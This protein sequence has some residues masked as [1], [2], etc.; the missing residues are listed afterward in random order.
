M[1]LLLGVGALVPAIQAIIHFLTQ[2][3]SGPSAF[4]NSLSFFVQ[5]IIE[6]TLE[7]NFTI[8][9]WAVT[10]MSFFLVGAGIFLKVREQDAT[11]AAPT[12]VTFG[13]NSPG[14][15]QGDFKI[16]QTI[17]QEYRVSQT[18]TW[19]ELSTFADIRHRS[20][21]THEAGWTRNLCE[22][23]IETSDRYEK[24]VFLV[25]KEFDQLRGQSVVIYHV[26][27]HK[28]QF[29]HALGKKRTATLNMLIKVATAR[30]SK[31]LRK[32]IERE[33]EKA[34]DPLSSWEIE[35]D[36][37]S[38]Y[39]NN[40]T[41]IEVEIDPTTRKLQLNM[42]KQK[43]LKP[44]DYENHLQSTSEFLKF[45]AAIDSSAGID[46]YGEVGWFMDDYSIQKAFVDLL[47]GNGILL[48]NV[49]VNAHDEEDWDYVN[50][51]YDAEVRGYSE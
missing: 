21:R 38:R 17:V 31:R 2:S 48:R 15:V 43:S 26:V 27:C 35:G 10:A 19:R 11:N 25:W 51:A 42:D 3:K 20:V 49:R 13:E 9:D 7:L 18:K 47:D 14:I 34:G 39:F 46:W 16:S 45:F 40:V 4:A 5:R 50:L 41:A 1:A 24:F 37:D 44:Q 23:L 36:A 28:S 6:R 12:V 30:F 8:Y 29:I 22:S 33:M 32:K